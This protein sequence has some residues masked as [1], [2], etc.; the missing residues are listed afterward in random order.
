M[1]IAIKG[2]FHERTE[3]APFIGALICADNCFFKCKNC[4]NEDIKQ[5]KSIY[6]NETEIINKV[7]SNKFNKGVILSGLEWSLQPKEMIK[8][9]YKAIENNLEVIV[10]TGLDI[11]KILYKI[12]ELKTKNIYIKCGKYDERKKTNNNIQYGVR[13][14]TTNQ[15][16]YKMRN[17]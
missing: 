16:I 11:K 15:K 1:N 13:L 9:I 14:D 12:P 17:I 10:Y 8:L 7:L 4:I 5:L 3:D 2:I 6:M